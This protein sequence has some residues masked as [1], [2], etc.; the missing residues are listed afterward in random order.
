MWWSFRTVLFIFIINSSRRLEVYLTFFVLFKLRE[1]Y[2][3][4][5]R[6]SKAVVVKKIAN[7]DFPP[8][9]ARRKGVLYIAADFAPL[10]PPLDYTRRE[11]FRYT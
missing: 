3:K 10:E 2:K 11:Q 5:I 6:Y 7:N 8:R 4:K 1:E 9:I